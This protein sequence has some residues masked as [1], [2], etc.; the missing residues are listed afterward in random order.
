MASLCLR[1]RVAFS[2]HQAQNSPNSRRQHPTRSSVSD[3]G[4]AVT[5]K[6][7]NDSSDTESWCRD[8]KAT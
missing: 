6:S 4:E 5:M 2:L 8:E 7:L 1:P 3:G